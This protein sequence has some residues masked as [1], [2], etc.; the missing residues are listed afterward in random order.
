MTESSASAVMR[1][2]KRPKDPHL[3]VRSQKRIRVT[4]DPGHISSPD[5]ALANLRHESRVDTIGR[6]SNDADVFL[7]EYQDVDMSDAS[8]EIV[9]FPDPSPMDTGDEIVAEGHGNIQEICY[10]AVRHFVSPEAAGSIE[11]SK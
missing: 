8:F 7:E 4:P 11:T 1:L 9:P 6:P 3:Q 2:P 10:G 5:D